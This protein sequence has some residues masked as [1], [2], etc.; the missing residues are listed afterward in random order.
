MD[1]Q[2]GDMDLESWTCSKDKHHGRATLYR[3]MFIFIFM[4]IFMLKF[5]F[6]FIQH[7]HE[8]L[9]CSVDMEHGQDEYTDT[10]MKHG[11]AVW[12]GQHGDMDIQ[13]GHEAWTCSIRMQDLLDMQNDHADVALGVF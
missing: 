11:N 3:L 4:F 12:K 2:Q 13:H 5:I 9:T 6:M 8:A 7:V 1:L 10:D